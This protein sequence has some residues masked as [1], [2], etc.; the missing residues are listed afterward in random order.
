M[1][2]AAEALGSGMI[3]SVIQHSMAPAAETTA[4]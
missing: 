3:L 2:P 1:L 4:Q